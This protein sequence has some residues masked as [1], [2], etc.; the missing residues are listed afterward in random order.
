MRAPA[1]HARETPRPLPPSHSLHGARMQWGGSTAPSDSLTHV[2]SGGAGRR[3]ARTARAAVNRPAPRP[4]LHLPHG[5][6]ILGPRARRAS[7][8]RREASRWGSWM[9]C[10]S[11]RRCP[12]A[13]TCSAV[14]LSSPGSPCVA[15]RDHSLASVAGR[16]DCEA[17]SRE[18]P[19][20]PLAT[21][22]TPHL[23]PWG[24]TEVWTNCADVRLE[25]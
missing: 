14:R 20:S 5:R 7:R 21:R 19:P 24:G 17:T 13:T 16:W 8:C 6:R 11:R 3:Q 4:S 2:G 15:H 1:N 10:T 12:P 18:L 23:A 22:A 9:C 25:H